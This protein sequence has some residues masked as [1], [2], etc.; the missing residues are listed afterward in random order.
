[1]TSLPSSSNA[2]QFSQAVLQ[3]FDQ[4]GR[5][6][7][8]WQQNPSPYRVWVSEIMLQQTQVTTVIPFYERFMQ[9][10]PDIQALAAATQDDVLNH[11]SGLGYYARGRNLHKAAVQVV[12]EHDGIMPATLD[13]LIALPGIGRSTAGAI[14]SLACG[15]SE[16]ILDGNVKRVLCRHYTVDGW[17]GQSA[18]EKYLWQLTSAVTPN[19]RTGEYNQAMMDLGATLCTRSSPGC[20]RCPVSASC[21]GLASGNPLQWPHKKP[22]KA[23]PSRE[24]WMVMVQDPHG[25]TLLQRRPPSGIWGGLWSFLQFDEAVAA[26]RYINTQPKSVVTHWDSFQHTFTH[27]ELTIHPIHIGLK[28]AV[29][30]TM[31]KECDGRWVAGTDEIGGLPAPVSRLLKQLDMPATASNKSG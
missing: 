7:L 25:R 13:G 12:Q 8:P 23:K 28:K 19:A 11:W 16:P 6:H 21:G 27:F 10:F 5:K 1:M 18:V 22:K 20:E 31:I 26:T 29:S 4:H 9:R 14:L 17:Y 24:T 30:P 3:W 15:Q 2:R